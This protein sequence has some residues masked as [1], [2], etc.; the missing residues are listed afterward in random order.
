MA[1]EAVVDV[2]TILS[3]VHHHLFVVAVIG[4]KTILMFPVEQYR[5]FLNHPS[6]EETILIDEFRTGDARQTCH[7]IAD[8]AICP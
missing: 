5:L 8:E 4:M 2:H 1:I 3:F 7:P 6:V